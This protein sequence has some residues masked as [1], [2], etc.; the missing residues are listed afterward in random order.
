MVDARA[1]SHPHENVGVPGAA[2]LYGISLLH[3]MTVSL[4]LDGDGLGAVWGQQTA[5]R[6]LHDAGF[7]NV[8]V[9]DLDGDFVDKLLH[10][11]PRL[12]PACFMRL[13][14]TARMCTEVPVL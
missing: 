12:Q 9:D 7:A 4:A 2:F 13:A 6:M 11:P 5:V 14:D 3:C 1:S 10:R 8:T